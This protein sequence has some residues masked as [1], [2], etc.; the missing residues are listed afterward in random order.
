[1]TSFETASA[2]TRTGDTTW[3]ATLPA[4]WA[5]GRTT[6]GGLQAALA[7]AVAAE[8][9]GPDRRVRTLDVG[10]AAPLPA[11]PVEIAAEVLGSGRSATQV[12]VTLRQDGVLGCRAYVVAGADRASSI[13]VP[14]PAPASPADSP[15]ASED[16]GTEWPYIEGLM[17]VFTQ[18]VDLRWCGDAFPFSGAG[19]ESA[20]IDGWCRHRTPASGLAA[21]VGMVDAW[22]PTVLPMASGFAPASTVRWS[23]HVVEPVPPGAEKGWFRYEGRTVHAADGYS[24]SYARIYSGGRL[25]VWSEQLNMVYD[26][27]P[28]TG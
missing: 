21:V 14:G 3:S 22:P 8:V 28:G 23:A 4:D 16:P 2:V 24:T 18:H 5:Q 9:A 17:P 19:P 6:F 26:R 20:V 12:Q 27:R 13:V 11:G 7:T 10:F 25:V 1:M 15:E